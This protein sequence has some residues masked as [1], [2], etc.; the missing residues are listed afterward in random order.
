MLRSVC[1]DLPEAAATNNGLLTM[2]PGLER[3]NEGKLNT[4]VNYFT[5]LLAG[6]TLPSILQQNVGLKMQNL[7]YAAPKGCIP[8]F[9]RQAFNLLLHIPEFS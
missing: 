3:S 6:L 8:N 9:G 2:V 4:N 5:G 7:Q 1:S